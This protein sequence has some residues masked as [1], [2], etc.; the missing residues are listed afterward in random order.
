VQVSPEADRTPVS[1]RAP[2]PMPVRRTLSALR[3]EG[4]A[5][6]SKRTLAVGGAV[7]GAALLT[8]VIVLA[9]RGESGAVAE[10]RTK[11][12]AALSAGTLKT[13]KEARDLG[14]QILAASPGDGETLARLTLVDALLVTD[15]GLPPAKD[16]EA[17]LANALAAKGSSAARTSTLQATCAILALSGGQ[18]AKAQQCAEKALAA[19]P[20]GTPAL[21]AA[22]RVKAYN[23]D[24]DGARR[25]LERLLQRAPDFSAAVL[26]WAAIWIDLGDPSTASQSLRDQIK[27]TG[28]HL[29]ARLLLAEAER[30]LGDRGT[31]EGLEAACRAESKQSPTLRVGCLLA[32]S[33]QSRLA[34]EHQQAVRSAR[35]AA[36]EIP[37]E[38]RLLAS[39]AL[40]LAVLGEVDAAD[41][42]LGRARK[43]ARE[44]A[45][46]VAW[47]DMAVRLGRHQAVV[48]GKLLETAAGPERRLVTAR[49]VLAYEGPAGLAKHL[50]S[51]PRGL[52]LIDPDLHAISQL[53]EE[54]AARS[55]RTDLEKR[56]DRGD[57]VAGYVLGRMLERGDPRQAARRL[58][59]ALWGHG[60]ACDAAVLYRNALRQ[61]DASPSVRLLRELRLRNAQCPAAQI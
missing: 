24:L 54:G 44:N 19:L 8:L 22:A 58:E 5:P 31:A 39:A 45:A 29:R 55:D 30:A 18:L 28:D 6:P 12:A 52:V 14:A 32:A 25:D 35:A 2:M 11:M 56:A 17:M 1:V 13:L 26:D 4:R 51:V 23:A 9:T 10:E 38:P 21:L 49:L 34:G 48:P 47:A 20:D 41:Q 60:D 3:S 57:P 46:P 43:L 37:D 36:A 33:A 59:K 61:L 27:R 42:A 50:K 53:A 40:T 15:Y 16:S 7:L